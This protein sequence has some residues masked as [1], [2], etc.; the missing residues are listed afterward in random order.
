[1][2]IVAGAPKLWPFVGEDILTLKSDGSGNGAL[3]ARLT[4]DAAKTHA[5]VHKLRT[6]R[7]DEWDFIWFRDNVNVR[8]NLGN[9]RDFALVQNQSLPYYHATN[10][11]DGLQAL[12]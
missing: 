8:S 12:S 2:A 9:V 3:W 7:V 4:P 11:P 1:M 6:M 5:K 10:P